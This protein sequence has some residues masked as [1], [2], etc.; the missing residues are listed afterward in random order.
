M[1]K[2]IINQTDLSRLRKKYKGK[3][4]G[5]AHGV[6]DVFHF[7]HLLHLQKAKSYCDILVVSLT[8]DKFIHKGPGRPFYNKKQRLNM[9]ASIKFVDF[10]VLSN[11]K[12]SKNIIKQLKPNIYF[13][14]NDY[15]IENKDFTGGIKIEKKEVKLKNV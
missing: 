14:G 11:E 9:L 3:K 6:F 5:L 1:I 7:G 12:L 8:K 10:V 15:Q 2:K 13:K 4:I